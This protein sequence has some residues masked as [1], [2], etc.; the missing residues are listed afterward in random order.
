[1]KE[2]KKGYLTKDEL[3]TLYNKE[4]AVER[5]QH[6]RDIFLFCCYTGLAYADVKKLTPDNI[7]KGLDGEYWIFVD[8]TKT[9]ST[10]N[11]PLLPIAVE[12]IEKYQTH[13]IVE[14][15]GHVLPV[16]SNQK[17]NAYL[18]ELATICGINKNITF[19]MAR[20]TFATTVTLSNGVSIE[21]VGSMLGHKNLKTTQI[22]AKVVQEK[23]SQDMK[24]LKETLA[25]SDFMK[26]SNQ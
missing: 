10:S 1:M 12:M 23:V 13:P 20:H 8:R 9:G 25:G 18:K 4:I 5:L 21:T 16:L 11:V 26:A 6:V 15:S 3:K 7:S 14:N 22:Y 24:K 17:M 19:H 2:V